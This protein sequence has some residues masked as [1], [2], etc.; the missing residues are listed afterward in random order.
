MRFSMT[1]PLLPGLP[2]PRCCNTTNPDHLCKKCSSGYKR[3]VLFKGGLIPT[4]T[5]RDDLD[6]S[7]G[8]EARNSRTK[9]LVP[10]VLKFTEEPEHP[11]HRPGPL[12]P[13]TLNFATNADGDVVEDGKRESPP[14]RSVPLIP[15]GS[16]P[17]L[18]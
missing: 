4:P 18:S 8:L 6:A 12:I 16:C 9:P 11:I 3:Y 1:Q 5:F 10:P 2:N 7:E 13:P 17:Q 15:P 14:Q